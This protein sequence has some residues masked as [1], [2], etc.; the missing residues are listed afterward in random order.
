MG[1]CKRKGKWDL[2]RTT[3]QFTHNRYISMYKDDGGVFRQSFNW[4]LVSL[5]I[6]AS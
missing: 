1:Y 4:K 3:E 5:D 6:K 2:K